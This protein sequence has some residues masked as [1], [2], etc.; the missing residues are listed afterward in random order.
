MTPNLLAAVQPLSVRSGDPQFSPLVLADQLI[1]LAQ[2]ADRAGYVESASRLIGLVYAV[3]DDEGPAR[4][5]AY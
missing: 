2:E 5:A 4:A 1:T 3:L